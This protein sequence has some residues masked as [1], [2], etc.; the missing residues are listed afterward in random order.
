[1]ITV[2]VYSRVFRIKYAGSYGTCFT[3][4][5]EGKQYLV[6][7]KHVVQGISNPGIVEIFYQNNWRTLAVSL[8]GNAPGETDIT[9]LAP[10]ERLSPA[11]PLPATNDGIVYTQDVYFL[12][13]PYNLFADV[14][15][16]NRNFPAP[17]VK[18]AILSSMFRTD[19]RIQALFLDGH[20]NPGFSGGP[21][22][23]SRAG[24]NSYSVAGVISSYR[25]E[26]EPVYEGKSPT[27]LVYR[28]NTGII[29]AYSI[30]HATELIEDNPIG[31]DVS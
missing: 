30:E 14:G 15:E 7:A 5:V 28:Y 17:F 20:N 29:I 4:D 22:V 1:M 21:V 11:M 19:D 9:V 8:V 27:T 10:S 25:Y 16:V 12:G 23:W 6:T 13:F 26:N 18:K 2:N 3:M 31:L 24:Q